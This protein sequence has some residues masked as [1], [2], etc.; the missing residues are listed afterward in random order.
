MAPWRAVGAEYL[1]KSAYLLNGGNAILEFRLYE[2]TSGRQLLAKR[3][4]GKIKDARKMAHSFSDEIL[5]LQTR[6]K[7]PFTSKIAFVSK[8]S[9]NK[10]IYLMDYDGYNVR[11]SPPTVPSTST[12][13]LPMVGKSSTSYKRRNTD[14]YRRDL[15]ARPARISSHPGINITGRW[16]PNGSKIALALSRDGNAEIYAISKDGKQLSRLTRSAAIETS[17]AWSPD[18][19][20]IAFLSDR[21]G[22]PQIFI[23][24]AD[25]SNSVRLTGAA[26]IM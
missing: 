25:G 22:K 24:N 19:G 23:M 20:R 3:Y 26:T 21:M 2:V 13:L 6:E 12:R 14:L 4:S 16:S 5:L 8:K 18:G 11:S 7:G 10:E 1:I 15:S 17:P 9:G